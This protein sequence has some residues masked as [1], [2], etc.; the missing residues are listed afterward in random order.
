M[1]RVKAVL[2]EISD[3]V[4]P[5]NFDPDLTQQFRMLPEHSLP[6]GPCGGKG[7]FTQKDSEGRT[8]E[9]QL[10]NKCF[11]LKSHGLKNPFKA[12]G[13]DGKSPHVSWAA[14]GSVDAA[15]KEAI[16][17]LGGWGPRA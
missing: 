13:E 1:E 6:D 2:S 7:N 3:R 8:I 12:K 9:V 17:K 10:A 4:L 16:R 5:S 11:Y 15:W 14:F